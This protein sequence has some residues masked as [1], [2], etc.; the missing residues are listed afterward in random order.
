MKKLTEGRL[1]TWKF[2]VLM[3]IN[4][5]N[6]IAGYM[7]LPLVASYALNLGADLTTASTVSGVMSL[8]SLIIL[9]GGG[10]ALR[11]C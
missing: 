10:G 9:P 1:W 4:L 2:V 3:L 8:V 5:T 6:G 11:L 7:T